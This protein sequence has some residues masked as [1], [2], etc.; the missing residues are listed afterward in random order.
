MIEI[1]LS[2]G[3]KPGHGGILPGEKVTAE[4]ADARKVPVGKTCDSPAFH[5][6]FSTPAGLLEFVARLRE[7]SGG[8]PVG[9]KLCVGHPW[10]FMAVCKA[11]LK[12]EITPDFIVVDGGEGGTGAA[13]LEL[14]DHMGTPLREGLV[15]VQNALVGAGVRDKIRIAVSGKMVSPGLIAA[16]MA[17][18]A[19][20]A[21]SA[22]GFM[23]A[24]GCLQTQRCHSNEC[25]VGIATQDSKLQ[26]ALV[27][28]DKARRV[29]QYHEGTVH[30]LKEIVAAAGLKHP[31]ELRP[32]HI[33][34]RTGP[35]EVKSLAEVYDFLE[36]GELVAGSAH[37]IFTQYWEKATADSFGAKA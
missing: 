26:K 30:V 16:G 32:E 3:A 1:K 4:I 25:P 21:N 11:M 37:P 8:K 22:R 20:W 36:P 15:F 23:F 7:L 13:P 19:D 28:E 31:S 5:K 34:M 24:L 33:M 2:Q 12:T 6:E 35:T 17:I 9:F 29:Y 14:S 10:E 18:G 27:V